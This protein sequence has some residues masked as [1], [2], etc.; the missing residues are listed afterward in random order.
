[1]RLPVMS[2]LLLSVSVVFAACVEE[3][4]FQYCPFDPC[5]WEQCSEDPGGV[6]GTRVAYSCAVADHPQC[7]DDVCLRF[8]GS[9]PFCTNVC[10]PTLNDADCPEGSSC[11]QY[12]GAVGGAE[13]VHYCVPAADDLPE[14]DPADQSKCEL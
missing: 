3:E 2:L 1:M 8:E 10:D 14:P 7:P 6:E 4:T 12:L 13:A 9:G 11:V 5:L